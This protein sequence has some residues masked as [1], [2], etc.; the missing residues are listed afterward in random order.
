MQ[1]CRCFLI[2]DPSRKPWLS[3]AASNR[4]DSD[5]SQ[6]TVSNKQ[7]RHSMNRKTHCSIFPLLTKT[8]CFQHVF[9]MNHQ[10]NMSKNSLSFMSYA[11]ARLQEQR[12]YGQDSDFCHLVSEEWKIQTWGE[13][14]NTN[15]KPLI[16]KRSKIQSILKLH[17]R[18]LS[19]FN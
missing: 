9:L 17:A 7:Q 19:V 2:L 13:K 15:K 3:P 11:M 18:Q 10:E 16:E 6:I 8:Y 4:Y 12:L 1:E 14:K 5:W